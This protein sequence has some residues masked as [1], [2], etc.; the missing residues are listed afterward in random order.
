[1]RVSLINV[2]LGV[3][4][5]MPLTISEMGQKAAGRLMKERRNQDHDESE[6][7]NDTQMIEVTTIHRR[8]TGVPT[9]KKDFIKEMKIPM[10]NDISDQ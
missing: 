1:M 4:S 8:K 10:L 3:S 6:I 5:S 2:A 7:S 9:N